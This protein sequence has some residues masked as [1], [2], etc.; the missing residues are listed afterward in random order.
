ML[1][2]RWFDFRVVWFSEGVAFLFAQMLLPV[3]RTSELLANVKACQKDPS[4]DVQLSQ[5]IIVQHPYTV[6][7]AELSRT[8]RA[9]YCELLTQKRRYADFSSRGLSDRAR[10]ELDS[11]VAAFLRNCVAQ[12]D[13]MKA[14]AVSDLKGRRG[15]ASFPAHQ[16]GGVAILNEELQKVS[17]LSE[18]LRG[19]RIRAAIDARAAPQVQ[20]SAQA[21]RE[22]AE[23]ARQRE[24]DQ[25]G[26]GPEDSVEFGLYEAEFAMEN[27]TLVSE[28]VETREKVRE[29]ERTVVEIANL[30]HVF[31]TKVL[32]QAREIESL[33]ELAL[34]ATMFL[35]RGNKELRKMKEKGPLLKYIVAAVIVFLTFLMIFFDWISRQRSIFFPF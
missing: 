31:A 11:S 27:A 24:R 1:G 19:V 21:A 10:D 26:G 4:R 17:R 6:R 14:Q 13:S 9:M 8:I 30:N 3:D 32:E 34:E 7:A 15:N 12:I 23:A 2:C 29:A 25:G 33:Y 16:I 28:L 18:E 5:Q 35:D 22:A 20:Y